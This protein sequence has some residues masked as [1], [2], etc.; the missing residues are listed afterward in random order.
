[1]KVNSADRQQLAKEQIVLNQKTRKDQF[2]NLFNE[3]VSDR[4]SKVGSISEGTQRRKDSVSGKT[5]LV[6]LGTIS[7]QKATVSD[8]LISHPA[9]RKDT[10]NIIHSEQNR[11]KPYTAIQAG[12]EVYVD[13]ENM[14]L[15]W[16]REGSTLARRQKKEMEESQGHTDTEGES[17]AGPG[18]VP[19]LI[20]LGTI[21]RNSPTVSHL[22]KKHLDYKQETYR[23][24]HAEKNQEKPY[25]KMI[26][27][28]TV[29]I[30]PK[31]DEI[32]W[33]FQNSKQNTASNTQTTK[34]FA[35]NYQHGTLREPDPFS[36]DLVE[37]V[38][39][40]VGKSYEEVD[41]FELIV[42]GLNKMGVNYEGRGGLYN[43]LIKM[44]EAKGLPRNAYLNGE[45]LIEA[46]GSQVYLKSISKIH[47]TD[48]QADEIYEEIEPLLMKGS[49]LSFSTQTRGHT[50]IVSQNNQ[51][52]TYI[53]SGRMDH[54]I[55]SHHD[56][57]SVGEEFLAGEIR[58]WVK[59]AAKS[60]E[61]LKITLG[62]LNEGQL[63][64]IK[65]SEYNPPKSSY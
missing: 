22:L 48:T 32:V 56:P 29:Y 52:W 10:W 20:E 50:G 8:L 1:M 47:D 43:Q 44:A 7:N 38:Q 26:K 57:K 18:E 21:S 35:L 33:N 25:T 28:T 59:L 23:I 13:L 62:R 64:G 37:A 63:R 41:C 6:L 49:I 30:N 36:E 24:I 15:V 2:S 46:S 65:T 54:H 39:H 34:Q 51:Y 45:G 61:H 14:E 9:Y 16:N 12:T 60:G 11:N 58:N 55:G 42:L 17:G 31:D 5:N 53:N 4:L 40:Y 3:R 27:G 19:E